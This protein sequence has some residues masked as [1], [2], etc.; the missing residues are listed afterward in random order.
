MKVIIR[1]MNVEEFDLLEMFLYEAIFQPNQ[2]KAPFSIIYEN[3]LYQYIEKFGVKEHDIC[4]CAQVENDIIG[5]VWVRETNRECS[6]TDVVLEFSISVLQHYRKQGIGRQLMKRMIEHI[7]KQGYKKAILSVQQQNYARKLYEELGFYQ[8][9]QHD[10]E[11]IM[12]K[13]L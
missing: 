10:Q 1:L 6:E 2:K 9:D 3:H 4:Y 5:A 12:M 7:R 8:V 13:Q 11:I